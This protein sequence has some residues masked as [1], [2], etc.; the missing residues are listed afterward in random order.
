[1]VHS[2]LISKHTRQNEVSLKSSQLSSVSLKSSQLPSSAFKNQHADKPNLFCG[3]P[4]P[5]TLISKHTRQNEVS[6][7]LSQLSSVSLK[8][9]QLP[10]SAFK[11]QHADKPN[12]FCGCPVPSTLIS[13]HTRQNEVS[14]KPS[15]LSS[16]S[17][18][19]S[20]LPSSALQNQHA[21]KPNLFCGCPV[22]SPS[23]LSNLFWNYKFLYIYIILI[24]YI[25]NNFFNIF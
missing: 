17:L 15:Q 18:K 25:K 2:T 14:L 16:V 8:S 22:D 7:K 21:D 11:N 20:Q 13:K 23:C 3:C 10:S 24:Y 12:L 1:L 5:S 19:P 4:V 6:L 9:S